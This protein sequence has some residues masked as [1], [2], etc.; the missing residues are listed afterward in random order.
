MW[1]ASFFFPQLIGR[2]LRREFVNNERVTREENA[3]SYVDSL[4]SKIIWERERER[5]RKWERVWTII[6]TILYI[7][8]RAWISRI[9]VTIMQYFETAQFRSNCHDQKRNNKIARKCIWSMK[10]VRRVSS[11]S[12]KSSNV[13]RFLGSLIIERY[14]MNC[15]E[16]SR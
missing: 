3:F 11:L 15:R 2:E 13:D 8:V 16:I 1:D 4:S 12:F 14:P 10:C 7:V 6:V 9:T 5:E